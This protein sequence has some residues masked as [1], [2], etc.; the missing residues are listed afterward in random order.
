MR[1][2]VCPNCCGIVIPGLVCRYCGF[3]LLAETDVFDES[4]APTA[5]FVET[6]AAAAVGEFS[7]AAALAPAE[8]IET[9][10]LDVLAEMD[11]HLQ[12]AVVRANEGVLQLPT[13]STELEEIAVVAKV[14]DPDA[15]EALSEVRPGMSIRSSS[16]REMTIVTGRIPI[17]KIEH[18]RK[19][20][21]VTSMK[22]SQ[23]LTPELNKTTEETGA[24]SELLPEGNLAN[25]GE[26]V[27]IGIIDYGCDF[28]HG[29]FRN[30]DGT[31]RVLAIWDQT[32]PKGPDSPYG[33]GRLYMTEEIN[34]ALNQTNPYKA[35][36]Y[37][38]SPDNALIPPGTHGT[39]VLDIAAGN[40][41]G[42][43]V[44]GMAPKAEIVFVD[45]AASDIPW[46][47][48]S[49][50]E[51]SFGDSVQ[52]LEAV[53]YIFN[54]AGTRPCVI[55]I[56][57][58][59]NGGPHDGTTLVEE[60][61]DSLI[62][63]APNRAVVIAASNSYDDGIHAAGRIAAKQSV[64]LIWRITSSRAINNELEIWYLGKDRFA[65]EVI[66]P[67]GNSRLRVDPGEKSKSLK[68]N[69][70]V[71]MVAANRLADP[72]NLDNVIGVFLERDLPLGEWTVRLHGLK[73]RD[74]SFH[75]WIERDDS[76][77]SSFAEPHDNTHTIGSISCGK[78]TIVVGSY[79]A[80]KSSLPLSYFSSAGPTRDGR[81]KPEVSAPGHDVLAAHSR[82]ETRTVRK[83]GTSMAAPAV[84]GTIALV[85]GEAKKRRR[86]LESRE[87]RELVV[88]AA[89]KEPPAG[90]AWD[91]RFGNGRISTSD[92]VRQTMAITPGSSPSGPSS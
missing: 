9:A 71:V 84:T 37:G 75:A 11:P 28:V 90:A 15:W 82:T 86:S 47:G 80:H 25:G 1:E 50:V 65:V 30:E 83:S 59:T 26:G 29:N 39:H 89:R 67:K 13:A 64:D 76:R 17:K 55:N 66:D 87:I 7:A 2:V 19:L 77:Q 24:R 3:P 52:L 56:S 51:K 79:D 70:K 69:D 46:S 31:S 40:G 22:A 18:V 12:L 32:G 45:V 78:E 38:P 58:G 49:V 72:N 81:E 61:I 41:R 54:F 33:Y 43:N 4:V 88:M 48:P 53:S 14:T 63:E 10:D 91:P 21:F 20:P 74:G 36:G 34:R 42:S 62:N 27:I 92:A 57:L 44:P 23:R 35:L 6:I 8:A 5:L 60:G 16:R 68:I 73:I 85:L